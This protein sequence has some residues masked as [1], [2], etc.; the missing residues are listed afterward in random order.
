MKAAVAGP[1]YLFIAG[2]QRSGTTALMHLLN[3]DRRIVLGRERYKYCRGEI[4]PGHFAP[5]RFF[6]PRPEETNYRVAE[7]YEN[8]RRRWE[9]GGVRYIGDKVPFYY[10]DLFHLA[11]TFPAV[12]IL[13]LV[14][15]LER[16]AA[17]Y[18]ARAAN[19][20][21]RM[22]KP[23][24]WR[25]MS[26]RLWPW[27][28]PVHRRALWASVD[29]RRA[30]MHWNESLAYLE[31]FVAAGHREQVFVVRYERLFAGDFGDL[32][33][34]YRFL[35]LSPSEEARREFREMTRNW[36]A[37]AAAPTEL[38]PKMTA[39]LAAHRDLRRERLCLALSREVVAASPG[40][41]PRMGKGSSLAS[42]TGPS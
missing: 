10:R 35:G 24:L 33:A 36:P 9:A 15:D 2:C 4:G 26:G 21:D 13:F 22:W 14:R 41:R 27:L 20:E 23:W 5:E 32:E 34:L 37:R 16:V 38:T 6:A 30:V 1:G 28:P 8:L 11:A 7:F 40:A 39:Y 29:Y 18:N 19:P 12:R 25:I 42:R 17:S 31:E 3:A